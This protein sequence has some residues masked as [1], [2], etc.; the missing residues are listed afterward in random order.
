MITL[1][2]AVLPC[3][4]S[5]EHSRS[6]ASPLVARSSLA[7]TLNCI[8][9]AGCRE[10]SMQDR[11]SQMGSLGLAGNDADMWGF[12]WAA[13][14]ESHFSQAGFSSTELRSV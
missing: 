1:L 11:T 13:A 3:D 14:R 4:A 10:A 2:S 7:S 9:S 5:R 6:L 8:A 12:R